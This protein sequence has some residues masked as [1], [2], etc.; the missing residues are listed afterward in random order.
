MVEKVW[1]RH[2]LTVGALVLFLLAFAGY[3]HRAYAYINDHVTIYFDMQGHG[4]Q[5]S[6]DGV[7]WAPG[8][9]LQNSWLPVPTASGCVFR[10]WSVTPGADD[11]AGDKVIPDT[12]SY[13]L[14]ARWLVSTCVYVFNGNGAT[15]G[16]MSNMTL[17]TGQTANLTPNYYSRTGYV[18]RNWNTNPDGTGNSYNNMQTVSYNATDAGTTQTITLYAQWDKDPSVPVTPT[19]SNNQAEKKYLSMQSPDL[20]EVEARNKKIII[21]WD[22][23]NTILDKVKKMQVQIARDR[24]FTEKVSG[25]RVG[26]YKDMV[27]MTVKKKGTYY[28]RVRYIGKGWTSK[29]SN[30]MKVKVN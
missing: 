6:P 22:T 3:N 8:D 9:V 14:Y 7:T 13:T 26:K 4:E 24:D 20:E 30:V 16:S 21:S 10:G 29:W 28:V 12:T 17:E 15:S 25:V 23:D 27:K 11:W 1:R 18:F 2:L 5:I 19:P